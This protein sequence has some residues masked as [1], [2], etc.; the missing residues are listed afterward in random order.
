MLNENSDN[1]DPDSVS[2]QNWMETYRDAVNNRRIDLMAHV[3]NNVEGEK[4]VVPVSA[5]DDIPGDLVTTLLVRRLTGQVAIRSAPM[6]FDPMYE[7][8]SIEFD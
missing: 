4:I 6:K 2:T 5:I 8:V 1:K 7:R 3:I